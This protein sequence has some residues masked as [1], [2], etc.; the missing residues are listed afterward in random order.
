MPE[1]HF[2]R[3]LFC[4]KCNSIGHATADTMGPFYTSDSFYLRIPKG[5]VGP[6]EIICGKCGTQHKRPRADRP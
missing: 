3:H 5:V 2:T 6:A 4:E 1:I